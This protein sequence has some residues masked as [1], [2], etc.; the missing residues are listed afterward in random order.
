MRASITG[1]NVRR[2]VG[3]LA[4]PASVIAV[5]RFVYWSDENAIG[6]AGLDGSRLRPRFIVLPPE[7]G[8]AAADG[9]ASDG[10][11]LFFSRCD[12]H[13]IGRADLNGSH[14]EARFLFTGPTSCPQGLAVAAGHLYWTE[15]G[16]GAIGRASLTG[17]HAN[18]TWLEIGSDLGPFQV[19][20]DRAHVYWTWGGVAG[21]PAYT[22][23]ANT[24]GTKLDRHFLA[25]SIY[26][27]ALWP[28]GTGG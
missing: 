22:G 13:T 25:D 21:T 27:L 7:V 8:G 12:D 6:R 1:G 15:L 3:G 9:L 16:I 2:L 18:G 20:A 5:H 24:N 23:R 17:R 28:A 11:H 4:S 19:V 14:I 10:T 26:P